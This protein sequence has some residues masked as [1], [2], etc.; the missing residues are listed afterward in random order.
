MTPDLSIVVPTYNERAR[1]AELVDAV[2]SVSADAG[3]ALEV[4][5]VDDASPDGTGALA[6]ALARSRPMQVV[7]RAGKLGLGS[8][9]VAGFAV[10]RAPVVGVMDADL[11]HPPAFVPVLYQALQAAGADM[12]VGSRYVPGGRI[13]AW[14]FWRRVLSRAGCLAARPLA[15]LRDATSGF[16]LIRR[17]LAQRTAVRA[18]GFKI[19]LELV[20][21]GGPA[22]LVEVPIRFDDRAAGESKMSWR[23]ATGYLVQLR[24]LYVARLTGRARPAGAYQQVPPVT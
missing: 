9:V 22:N 16:F 6:E 1:L 13:P 15:P 19:C 18:A 20:V 17:D 7:H 11:S 23:E 4:I 12:V 8:A 10:A 21:R 2:L 24:D 3:V 14:P 5:V